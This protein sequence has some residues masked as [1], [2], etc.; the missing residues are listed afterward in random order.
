MMYIVVCGPQAMVLLQL[1]RGD[2]VMYMLVCGPQVTA[3]LQL[4][5]AACALGMDHL[6]LSVDTA[7][8]PSGHSHYEAVT[9]NNYVTVAITCATA[10]MSLDPVDVRCDVG[11]HCPCWVSLALDWEAAVCRVTLCFC[12]V[13]VLVYGIFNKGCCQVTVLYYCLCIHVSLLKTPTVSH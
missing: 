13:F 12:N 7:S 2:C 3:Q 10:G 6:F 8:L 11:K 1:P 5:R 9:D 4:P